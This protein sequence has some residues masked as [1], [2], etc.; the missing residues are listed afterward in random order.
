MGLPNYGNNC[1]V[2]ATLQ[3][4]FAFSLLMED[5]EEACSA[6]QQENCVTMLRDIFNSRK[7]T[8]V[9]DVT[10]HFKLFLDRLSDIHSSYI[11]RE[12]QDASE[13]LIRLM[14]VMK[15]TF[16]PGLSNPIESH[17][18]FKMNEIYRCPKCHFTMRRSQIHSAICLNVTTGTLNDC[19]A[20]Y[21]SAEERPIQCRKCFHHH[22]EISTK[23]ETLPRIL[24]LSVNRFTLDEKV[25]VPVVPPILL[26]TR[27]YICDT[28]RIHS[29]LFVLQAQ[30]LHVG[31]TRNCG[32]YVSHIYCDDQIWRRYSDN[33]VQVIPASE[34]QHPKES[35]Y[36]YFYQLQNI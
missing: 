17:F 1:Y 4:L 12:Q 15:S 27:D 34:V 23:F 18:E 16:P 35:P 7:D 19:L 33:L 10:S 29:Q 13:F 6:V 28:S 3:V 21:L 31:Q 26:D 25:T 24:I 22:M 30:I 9:A 36:I 14:G 20:N 32:H 5:V 2:N 11:A 8:S